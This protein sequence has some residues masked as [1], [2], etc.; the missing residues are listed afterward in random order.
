M[1]DN[2]FDKD[3]YILELEK[4]LKKY[5]EAKSVQNMEQIKYYQGFSKGIVLIIRKLKI[6][7]EDELEVI[8]QNAKLDFPSIFRTNEI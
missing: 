5:Y 2:A 7:S 4:A 1:A 6:L 8:V 3:E